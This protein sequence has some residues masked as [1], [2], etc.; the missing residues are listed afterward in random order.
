[1]KDWQVNVIL[2]LA[3][4]AFSVWFATAMTGWIFNTEPTEV[5]GTAVYQL[6]N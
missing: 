5:M 6:I 4:L 3:L 1:M 2:L